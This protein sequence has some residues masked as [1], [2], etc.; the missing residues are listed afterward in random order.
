M[1]VTPDGKYLFFLSE[2]RTN[3]AKGTKFKSTWAEKYSDTDLY[4]VET[5]FIEDLRTDLADKECAAEILEN[6]KL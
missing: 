1:S 5:G 2:R 3:T 4:W 6:K